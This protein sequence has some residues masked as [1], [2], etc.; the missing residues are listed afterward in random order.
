MLNFFRVLRSCL[1]CMVC[2]G[3]LVWAS[4]PAPV[5][6]PLSGQQQDSLG[7]QVVPVKTSSQGQLLANAVVV[8][9]VGQEF[10]VSAPY[11]GHVARMLVG[12][13]DS[14]KSGAGLAQF[15]SP[16]LGDARRLLKEAEQ[17]Y[18]NASAAAQRDQA[19]LDEGVIPAVRLQLARSR[20]ET[21]LAQL[22]AREA[23]L[24]ATGMQFDADGGYATGMLRAP[25]AGTVLEAFVSLGQ[26]V[27]V[28]TVLFRLANDNQLQLDLQLSSDKAAQLQAGDEVLIDSRGAKARIT[29]VR[30]AVSAGQSAYARAVV[31]NRGSLQVGEL[32]SVTV[33]TKGKALA[34]KP[35][36]QWLIPSRALTQ[37]RGQSWL[38]VSQDKGF[39][40]R[41]VKVLSGSDD[42]S[43]VEASLPANAK[44]AVSGVVSLRALLQKDE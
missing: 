28:G 12:V 33:L 36:T 42:M 3:G 13:G 14:V 40:A 31:L 39:E 2:A 30:R 41:A 1:W 24:A 37:W 9:P 38:F 8:T 5:N 44:V 35:G 7:I 18:K 10:T 16:Q 21:A 19:L 15:T 27:E 23:E 22:R 43:L 17:E 6:L 4:E 11:A 20:Q 29:G 25:L 26:R 32:V 34:A